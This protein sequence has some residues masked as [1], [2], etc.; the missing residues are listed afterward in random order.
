MKNLLAFALFA[1]FNPFAALAQCPW[2]GIDFTS[3]EEV[4]NFKANYPGCTWIEGNVRIISSTVSNLDS[5]HEITTITGDLFLHGNIWLQNLE[6]LRNLDSLGGSLSIGGNEQLYSISGL[7]NLTTIG[8]GMGISANPSLTS[9]DGLQN[10][11]TLGGGFDLSWQGFVTDFSPLSNLTS[12]GG[13]FSL[14]YLPQLTDLSVFSNLETIGGEMILQYN[15]ALGSLNGLQGLDSLPQGCKILNSPNL[16]SLQGLNNVTCSGYDFS[17]ETCEKLS[18]LDGLNMLQTVAGSVLLKQNT[19]LADI[20]GLGKL[21]TVGNAFYVKENPALTS[22]AGLENLTNLGSDLEISLNPALT[23]LTALSQITQTPGSVTI[24]S[25][26][27]LGSLNGLHNLDSVGAYLV[28]S[29]NSVL[30]NLAGLEKIRWVG[31]TLHIVQNEALSDISALDNLNRVGYSIEIYENQLLSDCAVAGVCRHLVLSPD[32]ITIYSNAPGCNDPA[33]V[34]GQ[35]VLTP[36]AV[37]VLTDPDGDCQPGDPAAL[38]ATEATVLL[39]GTVQS[40]LRPCPGNAPIYFQTIDQTPFTLSV[41]QFS[42][43]NWEVCPNNQTFD[44]GAVSP[45]DTLRATFLL[46]PLRVCAELDVRLGLPSDFQEDCLEQSEVSVFIKNIGTTGAQGTSTAVVLPP[47]VELVQS[48]PALA[49]QAS[50]TLFFDLGDLLP[51]ETASVYMTVRAKC[52]GVVSG[53]SVCWSAYA[54]AANTCPAVPSSASE[55]NVSATC[56]GDSVVFVLKNIGGAATQNLHTFKIIKNKYVQRTDTF[57]LAPQETLTVRVPADGSTWRLEATK[58]DDG[59]RTAAFSEGCG[60]LTPGLVSVF[61]LEKEGVNYDFDCRQV[62]ASPSSA[63]PP[64]LT[65]TPTGVGATYLLAPGQPLQYT[66]EFQNPGS[67]TVRHVV[68]R[69]AFQP[70]LNPASFQPV[71]ASHPFEW[72]I[73]SG[74]EL[75]VTFS[76]I[77]LPDSL[78]N[79]AGSRGFFTFSVEQNP[80]LPTGTTISTYL[81]THFDNALLLQASIWHTIG[82]PLPKGLSCAPNGIQFYG[83]TQ[84]DAFQFDYPGCVR[85]V[86]PVVLQNTNTQNLNAMN[87]VEYMGSFFADNNPVLNDL[88]GLRNLDSCGGLAFFNNPVL[89]DLKGLENL[90]KIGGNVWINYSPGLESLTGLENLDSISGHFWHHGSN[91]SDL[92][93][94]GDLTYVGGDFEPGGSPQLQNL[95]GMESLTT[96]GGSF[97]VA[98]STLQNLDGLGNLQSIGGDV[99][100][101]ENNQLTGV[102]GL[103]KLKTIGGNFTVETTALLDINDLDSLESIGGEVFVLQNPNLYEINGLNNLKTLG[104]SIR[105]RENPVLVRINGLNSLDTLPGDLEIYL[106]PTLDEMFGLNRLKSMGGNFTFGY[107]DKFVRFGSMDSLLHVGGFF[108]VSNN[109]ILNYFNGFHQMH[110]TGG[111]FFIYDNPKLVDLFGFEQLDSVG[112]SVS[113]A[114]LPML[115]QLD[116]LGRLRHVGG[117]FSILQ[118]PTLVNLDSLINLKTIGG[119]LRIEENHALD[120]L[121]GFA[122][123]DSIGGRLSV[124]NNSD[125]ITLDG[126]QQVRSIPQGLFIEGNPELVNLD[127][128]DNLES[129]GTELNVYNN[130]ALESVNGLGN[131]KTI[132]SDMTFRYN[133]KLI[134]FTGMDKLE[135][136]GRNFWIGNHDALESFAGLDSLKSIGGYF[137]TEYNFALESFQGLNNLATVGDIFSV[138]FT[139]VLSMSGLEHL[140]SVGKTLS[141]QDCYFLETTKG[142]EGLVTVPEGII[143]QA[144][145]SLESLE[146][147]KNVASTASLAI[148]SNPSLTTLNGLESLVFVDREIWLAGNAVLSNLDGLK[149]LGSFGDGDNLLDIHGNYMLSECAILPVCNILYNAPGSVYIYDNAPDCNTPAEVEAYCNRTP[150]RVEVLLDSDADCIPDPSVTAVT[151]VQIHLDGAIQMSTR[152]SDSSG[153]AH[154]HFLEKG[155]LSLSLP[156]FPT[157][158]W[159]ACTAVISLIPGPSPL[160]TLHASFLLRPKNQCPELTT[161]LELPSVFRGCLVQSEVSVSTQNTGAIPAQDVRIAVVVP[162]VFEM[163]ATEPASSG[164]SGDT[165]FFDPGDLGPFEKAVVKLQVKTRCDTFLFGHTLCWESFATAQNLCP[166]ILPA[167]SVITLMAQCLADTAVRFTITNIGDAPTQAPHEYRIIRNAET[168]QTDVFSLTAHES[169]TVDLPADGATWRMEATKRDDG[170]LTAVALENCKGLTPGYINAFWLEKGPADYDFAC[171]EVIGAYDPNQKTAAPTGA[172]DNRILEQNI[173]LQYTIDFQNTGTDTAYRV[174]LRDVLPVGLD[175][176]S[177]RP[178]SASH[179]HTWQIRGA[180]TLEVLFSPIMLPD[181]NVNEPASHGFFTFEINQLPDL[182]IGTLLNNTASIIFDFNPP[183]F[184]NTVWHMIGRLLVQVDEPQKHLLLWRV[185]G[186]PTRDVATFVADEDLPGEKR[187]DLFDALGQPV[188]TAQFSGQT[189]EFRRDGLPAGWYVFRILD[190]QGRSFSGKI[191]LTD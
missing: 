64:R 116:R 177:F 120:D 147:L 173:P 10:I 24:Y 8:G 121:R 122:G 4:N 94:L 135:S 102:S 42:T 39:A 90:K 123:L 95:H 97:R 165:L 188:R 17:I 175:V 98:Y 151:G 62:V 159:E 73:R 47:E 80:D 87:E 101:S 41:Q 44:P 92:T 70:E 52:S 68:L 34:F 69:T 110:A 29:G 162:P 2:G 7:A 20:S 82:E 114:G 63:L 156:Q 169:L 30:T 61:W 65:A 67:D 85:I 191:L 32:K 170:T 107:N 25:N 109:A 154:F 128:L 66:L 75:E 16:T 137:S 145:T 136:V 21:N 140:S 129:I 104:T 38:P 115:S 108:N 161:R 130:P 186:N 60:G 117:S 149:N 50:D 54:T 167:F 1:I 185:W 81:I 125:L 174:L 51:F 190:G 189:F 157:G 141:I 72:V 133:A 163:L 96:V 84:V 142:L 22:L 99:W 28:I 77:D 48:D 89:K 9:L 23:D 83:Q 164:S 168:F 79:L 160:D 71:A 6:G 183:I 76:V 113:F 171:R 53:Q 187:F 88:T 146:G 55:I 150:V 138:F 3:Q 144:N 152:P 158:Y 118:N 180:D 59:S 181:S 155:P 184:T 13:G 78:T 126:L 15:T 143:I 74:N 178:L 18:T 35:C 26:G 105:I 91:V 148:N 124:L 172:G 131:L 93:P 57:S 127:G 56:V 139:N 12:I 27:Q 49:A 86:G 166:T 40:E 132:G 106:N 5:L 176:V 100:F 14:Q 58:R 37:Q 11:T 134:D 19:V 36:V 119:N 45:G 182:P 179:P 111:S 43:E 46:K 153:L 31:T 103:E 112:G 33:E